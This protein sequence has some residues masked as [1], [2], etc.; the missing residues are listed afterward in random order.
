[1]L[2]RVKCEESFTQRER[3]ICFY[4][5]GRAAGACVSNTP[6]TSG[7]NQPH[8]FLLKPQVCTS[9]NQPSGAP[10]I[11]NSFMPTERNVAV[12]SLGSTPSAFKPPHRWDTKAA[13][14][15]SPPRAGYLAR[16]RL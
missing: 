2:P 9:T 1:M 7:H 11:A 16:C 10:F 4:A 3:I 15:M 6:H 5:Q 8:M 14:P 13:L 12:T